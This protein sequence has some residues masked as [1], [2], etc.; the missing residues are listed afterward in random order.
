M[1]TNYIKTS[2]GDVKYVEKVNDG[3]RFYVVVG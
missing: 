1:M 2:K 3:N